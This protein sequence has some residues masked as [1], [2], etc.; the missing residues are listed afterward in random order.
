MRKSQKMPKLIL[1]DCSN[2]KPEII[3]IA[4]FLM[5]AFSCEKEENTISAQLP[6]TAPATIT[7][8]DSPAIPVE[9]QPVEDDIALAQTEWERPTHFAQLANNERFA[10]EIRVV[11]NPQWGWMQNLIFFAIKDNNIENIT[12]LFAWEDIVDY[13]VNFTGD[14]RIVFFAVQR[15]AENSP[16]K[17]ISPHYLY[18]ADGNDGIIKR[19]PVNIMPQ[20]R[21][22]KDGK[23]VAFL[24]SSEKEQANIFVFDVEK[25]TRMPLGWRTNKPID[26]AWVFFR[27]G[28]T[29]RIYGTTEGGSI[30]AAADIYPA[31][32]ELR[33]LWDITDRNML[34]PD[35]GISP[36]PSL[37]DLDGY[38]EWQDDVLFQN[39]DPNIRLQ[40]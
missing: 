23:F 6:E 25:G 17:P 27:F 12:E 32:M 18:M 40:R 9:E 34:I 30:A 16:Y 37:D 1:P 31:T 11:Q 4:V 33:I 36:I 13:P 39:W 7:T 26:G 29:F 5:A 20:F 22:T 2:K 10:Y 38:N 3:F 8:T 15:R 35:G 21:V 28:N 19:L 14:Y 24:N